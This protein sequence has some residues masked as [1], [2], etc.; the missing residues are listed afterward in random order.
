VVG[1]GLG[2]G[3]PPSGGGA[4]FAFKGADEPKTLDNVLADDAD[5]V[6]PI[7]IG[8]WHVEL[9]A[10]FESAS[11][12]PDWKWRFTVPGASTGRYK[13]SASIENAGN[14]PTVAAGDAR[15][16][17]GTTNFFA[18]LGVN[19]EHMYHLVGSFDIVAAGN[20]A[21]QWAQN[22]SNATASVHKKDS[23][24]RLEEMK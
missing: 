17:P 11:L 7:T 22:N 23:F 15:G 3:D 16:A 19:L 24:L 14:A 4:L 2:V 5:L 18:N 9:L 20:I 8:Q 10:I 21:F 1:R 13:F 6:I 12:T